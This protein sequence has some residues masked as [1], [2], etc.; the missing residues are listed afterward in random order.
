MLTIT[1]AFTRV[2]YWNQA[3]YPRTYNKELQLKLLREELE[4]YTT[5]QDLVESMDAVADVCYVALGGLW[6][7]GHY[8]DAWYM[9]RTYGQVKEY[10]DN[11]ATDVVN[12][13]LLRITAE[14]VM[15]DSDQ[16]ELQ[17][18]LIACMFY[19]A[20]QRGVPQSKTLEC[21]LAVCDSNDTK[22]IKATPADQKA[23]VVKGSTYVPPTDALKAILS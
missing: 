17:Y 7:M 6:K 10:L 16:E 9:A 19:E 18:W 2:A 1:D 4:E 20:E 3:R 11:R 22:E 5:A 14:E 12:N 13:A 8:F 21:L 23:N 15:E